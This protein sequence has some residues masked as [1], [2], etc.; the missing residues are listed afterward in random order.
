MI[1]KQSLPWLKMLFAVRGSAIT[2]TLPRILIITGFSVVVTVVEMRFG[3]DDRYSLTPTPFMLIGVALSIFLGFRNNAAYDRYWEGRKLWGRLVN[4]S[5]SFTRQVLTLIGPPIEGVG[6]EAT[7]REFQDD[8]VRRT[9]AYAHALRH[10]LRDSDPMGDLARFLPESELEHLR[11]Q[12]N[13]PI[14][15]LQGVGL[16]LRGAWK[17]GWISEYHLPVLEASLTELTDIQGGC[18]RIKNTPVPFA[19]TV[20]TH[21]IVA[22]YCFFL[23]FGLVRDIGEVTPFVVFLISHAFFGLDEIGDE[24]EDPFGTEPQHLPL[25]ALCRTIEV[26]LLQAIDERD[27]PELLQP[28]DGI[29]L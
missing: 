6:D 4:T 20:L 27:V 12:K 25:T 3:I 24:V 17:D 7:V 18:E 26:N 16:R 21:R 22:F 8:L 15:I 10:H 11:T 29:L 9:I 23:P 2:R 14:A 13:V 28:V 19:Y 1:V 5:R